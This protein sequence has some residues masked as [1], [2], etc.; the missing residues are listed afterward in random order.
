MSNHVLAHERTY[1]LQ[2]PR[3]FLFKDIIA[4]YGRVRRDH[5]P[6]SRYTLELLNNATG[7]FV[8]FFDKKVY[9]KMS[10]YA[11]TGDPVQRLNE[12]D[13]IEREPRRRVGHDGHN[14]W[15]QEAEGI[16][17]KNLEDL[18]ADYARISQYGAMLSI[19]GNDVPLP[20]TYIASLKLRF[21]ASLHQCIFDVYAS[22][23]K[24]GFR[25]EREVYRW[26][27][28]K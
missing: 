6:F 8:E 26:L 19:A 23:E 10:P 7:A 14:M 4:L 17:L 11:Y 13:L 28:S 16:E 21:N 25:L 3:E 20:S 24:T 12:L 18:S 2:M 5:N 15:I 1:A 22:K 9:I 27:R